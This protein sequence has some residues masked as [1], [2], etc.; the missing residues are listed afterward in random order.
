[1][2]TDIESRKILTKVYLV[3]FFLLNIYEKK[4]FISKKSSKFATF[5][6]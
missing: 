2:K 6:I 3:D 4:V 5:I 1:M